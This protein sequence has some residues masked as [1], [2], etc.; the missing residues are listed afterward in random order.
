IGMSGARIARI[1]LL[2]GGLIGLLGTGLGLGLGLLVIACRDRI[3]D[4]LSLLMGHEVFP[5]ELYHL[6][7]I[8]ALTTASDLLLIVALSLGICLLAALLPALYAAS[9]QPAKALQKE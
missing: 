2:Q 4:L 1:F 6:M 7:K 5:A 3:A 8:P 9:L